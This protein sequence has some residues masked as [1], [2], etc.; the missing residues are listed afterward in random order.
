VKTLRLSDACT[1]ICGDCRDVLPTLTG[2]DA[3]VTDPPYG[4][5]YES[6]MT[7]HD[8]GTSLGGIAGD[9]DVTLRDWVITWMG[10]RS[11]IIFGSWKRARPMDCRAVLI[12]D[13]GHHVG[14]GDLTL[15]WKPNIEEI[16]IIGHGFSGHR[17]GSVLRFNAPVSWNSVQFG[18]CHPHEKPVALMSALISKVDGRCILDPFMGSGTT[19]I[20]CLRTGRRFI[21]IEIDEHYFEIARQRL[22]NE[23]DQGR[24]DL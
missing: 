1:I 6:G 10:A 19:G 21:G 14:M 9:D 5:Q 13:K 23:I 2:V 16:Y 20:A 8:G 12:W 3:V 24:L 7:G 4:I 17:D 11:G 22:Q 18:R 15:P